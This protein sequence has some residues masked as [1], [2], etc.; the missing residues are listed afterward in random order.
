MAFT[1]MFTLNSTGVLDLLRGKAQNCLGT[2]PQQNMSI[3]N[4]DDMHVFFP[5]FFSC[6]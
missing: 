4:A 5:V 3:D 6:V 1:E 2:F